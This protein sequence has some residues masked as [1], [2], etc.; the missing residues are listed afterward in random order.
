VEFVLRLMV[1]VGNVDVAARVTGRCQRKANLARARAAA[2]EGAQE[3]ACARK[4]LDAMIVGV[5]DED[6][7]AGVE[8]DTPRID[9]LPWSAAQCPPLRHED[10][11]RESGGGLWT[12]EEPGEDEGGGEAVQVLHDG[13]IIGAG[14]RHESR[15]AQQGYT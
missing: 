3:P 12:R 13:P 2:P 8:R 5:G 14:G 10:G 15:L 1:V 7:A 9:E 11:R 4:L 6:I